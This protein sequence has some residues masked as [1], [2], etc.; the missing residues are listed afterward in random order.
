M[1]NVGILV[2]H[3]GF[4]AEDE[5][6][7]NESLTALGSAQQRQR[8]DR[9]TL[10][11]DEIGGLEKVENEGMATQLHILAKFK[12]KIQPAIIRR[13]IDSTDNEGKKILNLPDLDI[14]YTLLK[15]YDNEYQNQERIA[16]ELGGKSKKGASQ[17]Q[18]STRHTIYMEGDP[19]I[20]HEGILL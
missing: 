4:L 15:L 13:T 3:T 2:G 18:V 5:D 1:I 12:L 11:R 7:I 6:E 19:L 9:T 16:K 14:R 20:D 10:S 17:T 8:K